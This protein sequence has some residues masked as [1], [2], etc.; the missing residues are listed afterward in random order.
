MSDFCSCPIPLRRA[1]S[2]EGRTHHECDLC[3]KW[4]RAKLEKVV[5]KPCRCGCGATRWLPA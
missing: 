1:V 3:D 4:I 5:A 2:V